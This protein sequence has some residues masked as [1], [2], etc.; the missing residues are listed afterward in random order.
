MIPILFENDETAFDN[1]GICRLTDCISCVVTEER[2]GVYE[3]DFEYPVTGAYYDQITPGRVISCTHDDTGTLQPFDIVGY[4]RSINGVVTFHAVHISY[5]QSEMTVSGTGIRT[6][7][8]ALAMLQ[9]STPTNPFTYETDKTGSS[10]YMSAA[11]GTPRTVRQMLGGIEGSILD[12]YGGEYEW[13]GFTVRLLK[14]RG[15]EKDFAIRYG[16]NLSNYTEDLD[17]QGTYSAVIPFWQKD[18]DIV[19]GSMVDSGSETYASRSICVPLNLSEKFETKPT[20]A[21]LRTAA[22]A[23]LNANTPNV[24]SQNI[25]VDFVRL[26]DEDKSLSDLMSCNLCDSVRVIFPMYGMENT[27][28]IVK[29]VYNVLKDRYDS[30]ELGTLGTTLSEALGI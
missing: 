1:N 16:L 3:C 22:A 17:Y 13:D 29:V 4:S 6:L 11:D 9:T 21:Q 18:D 24:P 20:T 30:M 10:G 27:F 14:A 23:Y 12:T 5:R 8:N 26:Q 15:E 2:N 28:K 19:T 7:A 25:N